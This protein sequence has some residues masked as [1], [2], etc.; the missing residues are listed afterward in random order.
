MRSRRRMARS[1]CVW[2]LIFFAAIQ[3]GLAVAIDRYWH[4]VRDPEYG[5]KLAL[6]SEL[7]AERSASPTVVVLGSSRTL[8]GLR[9]DPGTTAPVRVFNF[10]LT[11]H[12]PVNQLFCLQRLLDDGM[13]PDALVVEVAPI[14]L[15]QSNVPLYLERQKWSDLMNLCRFQ[16][17]AFS[18]VL[19][20][21]ESRA[22]PC[23]TYR[24]AFLSRFRPNWLTWEERRD[25][26]W[27]R[28]DPTGWYP[29]HSIDGK[30]AEALELARTA[31][32][33]SLESFRV[34]P[35]QDRALRGTIE[36]A[37]QRNLPI[38]LLLMPEGPTFQSWYSPASRH[39]I[40]E[41]L[42]ALSRELAVR[43]ID[44]RDWVDSES[45][46][47]DG[48]HLTPEGATVFSRRFAGEILPGL[49]R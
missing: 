33:P 36:L 24:F 11:G 26:F 6:L 31:F 3:F 44:T 14:F 1:T 15:A 43:V 42:A 49:V 41:Y 12:G 25:G 16:G 2:S 35:V 22:V 18:L 32:Q 38:T 13:I 47:A 17:E 10:G 40:D 23:F 8:N 29:H 9:P 5:T 30:Q 27:Q 20:W 19:N 37:R 7:L 48:H 21:L 4:R 45:A 46:F 34:D 28:T 39:R